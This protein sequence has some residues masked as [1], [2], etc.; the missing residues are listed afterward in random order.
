MTSPLHRLAAMASLLAFGLA[1]GTARAQASPPEDKVLNIYNWSDYIA[2]DTIANFE[3]ETGIKVRYDNFDSNEIVH[4]KLVAGNSGYD[5]VVPSSYWA[6]MQI[7][8][9]LL[10]RL[11]K[12]KLPNLK[13]VDP[14]VA[15]RLAK[16]DPGNDH[17]EIGRASCRERVLMSV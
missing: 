7:Q 11:D 1:A 12:S 3:K 4:A 6:R 8:G 13:N 10:A 5:V 2:D 14:G 16:I 9:D 17:L 15:A